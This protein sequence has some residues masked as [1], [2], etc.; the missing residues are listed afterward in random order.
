MSKKGKKT[1]AGAEFPALAEKLRQAMLDE[2]GK[3]RPESHLLLNLLSG[4][5]PSVV[6][7]V[8]VR[9]AQE[10]PELS[11]PLLRELANHEDRHL[12]LAASEALGRSRLPEAARFLVQLEEE[13]LGLKDADAELKKA[14]ARSLHRLRSTGLEAASSANTRTAQLS[15]ERQFHQA[16][17][18]NCDSL[19]TIQAVLALRSPGGKL[20]T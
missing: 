11:F 5:P 15:G 7:P 9:L 6:E 18:S 3:D 17:V 19:G 10:A 8:L 4:F 14:V 1:G 16:L 13:L 2:L 12:S 20:E